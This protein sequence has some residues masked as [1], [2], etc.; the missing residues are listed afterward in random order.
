M[1]AYGRKK[2][3]S[4]HPDYHPKKPLINW[5]E[6]EEWINSKKKVRQD[7]KRNILKEIENE[8]I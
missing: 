4:N 7:A 5:W 3:T 6:A 2:I 1:I 8:K